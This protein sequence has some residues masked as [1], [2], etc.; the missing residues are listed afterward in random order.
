MSG[1]I[2]S[3]GVV[4]YLNN[5]CRDMLKDVCT[6]NG[7]D[8]EDE[9]RK[10]GISDGVVVVDMGEE[11]SKKK[12]SKSVVVV[13]E[14]VVVSKSYKGSFPLP[15]VG[16][17]NKDCC[18][19]LKHNEGLMTQCRV[20]K[21]GSDEYCKTCKN[22][23]DKNGTGMPTY[24]CIKGRMEADIYDYTAPNGEHVSTYSSVMLKY[25][26]SEEMV[27][28]EASKMNMV[29]DS[30]H[31]EKVEDAPAKKGRPK[32]VQ[33]EAD[34]SSTD[35]SSSKR[36]RPKKV[37]KVI[38]LEGDDLF[39][40]LV[41]NQEVAVVEVAAAAVEVAVQEPIVQE[42]AATVEVVKKV[43]K[44]VD[45]DAKKKE[46]EA[47]EQ[48]E[49]T[50]KLEEEAASK[51]HEEALK[52]ILLKKEEVAEEVDEEEE[53]EAEKVSS[54]TVD[55]KKYLKSMKSGVVYD[56]Q[57]HDEIGEWNSKTNSID[58]YEEEEEEYEEE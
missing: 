52:A 55:G 22:Q 14:K 4:S 39:A 6:R 12:S 50:K 40:S 46:K 13:G 37:S 57:S 36:G 20:L 30:R 3:V 26:L 31:F 23:A 33:K 15:F 27:L 8:Y 51:A 25:N 45:K 58:F 29:I 11:I 38:E 18:G 5:M 17:E 54:I 21:K 34:S 47:K 32:A 53:E 56:E 28:E 44:V 48:A 24:G 2:V 41:A 9:C 35:G 1:V 49:K 16:V 43:K 19:G 42:V 7:L 10:S